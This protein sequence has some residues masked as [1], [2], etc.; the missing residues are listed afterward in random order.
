MTK[1]LP[2][3]MGIIKRTNKSASNPFGIKHIDSIPTDKTIIIAI[4]G[5][6]T[7]SEKDANWYAS[8]IEQLFQEE[9]IKDVD[10][11]SIFYEFKSRNAFLDRINLFRKAGRRI[12][13]AVER[14][15]QLQYIVENEPTPEFIKQFYNILILPRVARDGKR[16]ETSQ[17][18]SNLS[19]ITVLAHCHGAAT[20]LYLEKYMTDQMLSLGYKKTEIKS[21]QHNLLVVSHSPIAPLGR[22]NFTKLSFASAEDSS[23]E[24]HNLFHEYMVNNSFDIEPSYFPDIQGNLFVTGR[25]KESMMGE[26]NMVGLLK[27]DDKPGYLTNDG[28]ILFTAERNAVTN[29]VKR[30]Q[31]PSVQQLV[32]GN[33]INFDRMSNNGKII[34]KDMVN[35]ARTQ[36]R[37]EARYGR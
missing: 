27:S 16:I 11:Y 22:S 28:R 1:Y 35:Y 2:S 24:Y 29:G 34:L 26:H 17:A 3:N 10:I 18:E 6:G 32:S 21:I 5:E 9:H 13:L 19:N 31:M 12:R 15:N 4:G 7:N 14:E 20:M 33:G 25:L 8:K 37:H 30:H 36:R 23:L